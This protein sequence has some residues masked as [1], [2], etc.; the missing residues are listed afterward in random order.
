MYCLVVVRLS[1][2]RA[3]RGLGIFILSMLTNLSGFSL[4][5][6][7]LSPA[8]LHNKHSYPLAILDS[9][10]LEITGHLS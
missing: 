8:T 1:G 2:N 10:V 5:L 9:N 3:K 6:F 4:I 7:S